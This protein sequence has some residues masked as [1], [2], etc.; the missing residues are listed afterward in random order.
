MSFYI[1]AFDHRY[2]IFPH[3]MFDLSDILPVVAPF[4]HVFRV[5]LKTS[6]VES[7]F[8]LSRKKVSTWLK[9][10]HKIKSS[11]N[12]T[13]VDLT[14]KTL[15]LKMKRSPKLRLPAIIDRTC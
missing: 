13:F 4:L 11:D 14:V 6:T 5:P 15:H 8:G 1:H 9:V 3:F 10:N 7:K 2:I 12:V